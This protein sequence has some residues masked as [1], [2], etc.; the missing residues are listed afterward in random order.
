MVQGG[1]GE[2][3]VDWNSR[4]VQI[5]TALF[6]AQA[7]LLI[8]WKEHDPVINP[9]ALCKEESAFSRLSSQPPGFL[10]METQVLSLKSCHH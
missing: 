1:G 6:A 9:A 7:F 5:R 3:H 10:G 2:G 8:S 4:R